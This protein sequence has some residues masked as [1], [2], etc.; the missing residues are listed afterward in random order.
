MYL[1]GTPSSRAAP[2]E[3]VQSITWR[4]TAPEVLVGPAEQPARPNAAYSTFDLTQVRWGHIHISCRP[5]VPSMTERV[6]KLCGQRLP[7]FAWHLLALPRWCTAW[8]PSPPSGAT[9]LCALRWRRRRIE[10]AADRMAQANAMASEILKKKLASQRLRAHGRRGQQFDERRGLP[11]GVLAAHT[12]TRPP[13]AVWVPDGRAG[14][15]FTIPM[16][17]WHAQLLERQRKKLMDARTRTA[18]ARTS[19]C[20]TRS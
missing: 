1:T 13:P 14:I 15:R 18:A 16:L 17:V 6:G 7:G 3:P 8:T 9:I 11:S 4:T 5:V 12:A 10:A 19:A 20:S 2:F